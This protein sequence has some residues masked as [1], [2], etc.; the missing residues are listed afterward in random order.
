MVLCAACPSI[1]QETLLEDILEKLISKRINGF[2]CVLCNSVFKYSS[3]VKRHIKCS[4]YQHNFKINNVFSLL[5]NRSSCETIKLYH[6]PSC[7]KLFPKKCRAINHSYKCGNRPAKTDQPQQTKQSKTYKNNNLKVKCR[8][9]GM[10]MWRKNLLTHIRRRHMKNHILD[11][12]DKSRILLSFCIDNKEQIY[13]VLGGYQGPTNPVHAQLKI[14][15]M[16]EST[17]NCEDS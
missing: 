6:C 3:K 15:F 8:V 14:V 2:E 7:K 16:E 9:C 13:L 17:V 11:V 4:H 1:I 12:A 10:E 5:C